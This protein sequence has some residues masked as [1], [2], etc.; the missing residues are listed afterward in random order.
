MDK[1]P[2][3]DI[4][5]FEEGLR[6]F[7]ADRFPDIIEHIASTGDLPKEERLAEAIGAY[8]DSFKASA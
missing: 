6:R 2:I 3:E 7:V 1:T 8:K 5:R 4:R